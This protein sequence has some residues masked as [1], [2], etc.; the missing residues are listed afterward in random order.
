MELNAAE[1]TFLEESRGVSEHEVE[2]QRRANRRLRVLLAGAAVLLLVA[3]GAGGFAAAQARLAGDS[4][5]SVRTR[6]VPQPWPR[7]RRPTSNAPLHAPV[8]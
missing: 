7:L 4:R 8:S 2:R 1:R 6:S 5:R 3:V